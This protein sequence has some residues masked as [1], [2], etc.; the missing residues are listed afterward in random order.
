MYCDSKQ[1]INRSSARS[2]V[3]V[4]RSALHRP[5]PRRPKPIFSSVTSVTHYFAS[6]GKPR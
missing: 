4:R 1:A 3:R 2:A 6:Y 5:D